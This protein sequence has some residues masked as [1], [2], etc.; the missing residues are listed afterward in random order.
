MRERKPAEHRKAEVV[1]TA[2]ALAFEAGPQCVTTGMIAGRLGLTQ[3]AIYR[4]FSNKDDIWT[5]VA[6]YLCEQIAESIKTAAEAPTP[7]DQ[8]RRLVLGHLRLLQQVP[9]LP[10]FMISHGTGT[11]QRAVRS[12][13]QAAMAGFTD[14][15]TEAITAAQNAGSLRFDIAAKDMATLLL[16]T[17]QSLVLRLLVTRN[18]AILT[19][20]GERLLDLQMSLF[21]AEEGSR[22]LPV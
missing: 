14:A 7:D 17:I 18:P 19:G 20:E 13:I 9:A 1:Q 21:E 15:L 5:S 8:L 22:R 10:E 12:Q 3:P 11:A 6:A 2:L 16:G 4:H